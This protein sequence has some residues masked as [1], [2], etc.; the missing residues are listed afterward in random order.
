ML[1]TTSL[2]KQKEPKNSRRGYWM[3]QLAKYIHSE[4]KLKKLSEV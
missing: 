3:Q 2:K 4:S 1:E